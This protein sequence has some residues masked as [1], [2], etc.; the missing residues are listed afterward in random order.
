MA[1]AQSADLSINHTFNPQNAPSGT[2][3]TSTF[4]VHNTGPDAATN[5]V[6][7]N[8]LPVQVPLVS[9]VAS[10]FSYPAEC[11]LTNTTLTCNLGNINPNDNKTIIIVYTLGGSIGVWNNNGV[12]SSDTFDPL[13]VNNS[14]PKSVT[15]TNSSNLE[16]TATPLGGSLIAGDTFQYSLRV[17][18]LGP[19]PVPSEAAIVI[20]YTV[21]TNIRVTGASSGWSCSPGTGDAGTVMGCRSSGSLAV[22]GTKNLTLNAVAMGALSSAVDTSFTL[23]AVMPDSSILPDPNTSNNNAIITVEITAGSDVSVGKTVVI[24]NEE[25][26]YTL[27]PRFNGGDSLSNEPITITD[28]YNPAEFTFVEWISD[29]SLDGW[30]CT[31]PSPTGVAMEFSCTR[32]GYSGDNFTNMPS[33]KFKAAI[34]VPSALFAT[35]IAEIRLSGRQD[36][37]SGNNSS[38]VMV[39]TSGLTDMTTFKSVSFTPVVVGQ[40]FQYTVFVRNLGPW[41]VL[42]GQTITVTDTLPDQVVITDDPSGSDWTCTVSNNGGTIGSND[43]PVT[44]ATANPVIISCDYIDG[45]ASGSSSSLITIPAQ[46]AAEGE[47]DNTACV[48]LAPKGGNPRWREELDTSN[49]CSIL[50]E[51][52]ISATIKK[53]DLKIAKT[54]NPDPVDAG[55]QLTYTLTVINTGPDEATD[56]T[57]TDALGS[58]APTGGLQQVT[59]ETVPSGGGACTV[60]GNATPNFP[61]NG[62]AHLLICD[63]PSLQKDEQAVV[64]VVVLPTIAV[65]GPRSNTATVYS[66]KIGDPHRDDN[67]ITMES[68][69]DEVYDLTVSAWATSAGVS[70]ATQA[71]ANSVILFTT[72]VSSIGPST[73]PTAKV[74]I[75]LPSNAAFI[76]LNS[77]GGAT[78]TSV[79]DPLSGTTGGVLT[80]E[81]AGGIPSN[82]YRDISYQVMAPNTVGS[83]IVSVAEVGLIDPGAHDPESNLTNNNASAQ[84]TI[85]PAKADIQASIADAPDPIFLGELTTYTIY[86]YNNGPSLATDVTLTSAFDSPTGLFSYQGALTV[87]QGGDC[88]EPAI[89]TVDGYLTCTWSSLRA[90]ER[91]IITYTMHA[92]AIV[93]PN[94][95][96]IN[97]TSVFASATEEDDYPGNDTDEENTTAIRQGLGINGA[98]LGITKTAS[99]N[100]VA[101]DEQFSYTLMVHNYGPNDV[102]PAQGAQIV[103]ILPDGVL[104]ASI[105]DDCSYV[106]AS[107]T[108]TCLIGALANG[109]DHVVTVFVKVG[110]INQSRVLV[111]TVTVDMPDDLD[112]NNNDAAVTV[113]L[114]ATAIPAMS[115]WGLIFLSLL[116]VLSGIWQFKTSQRLNKND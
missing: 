99:K 74:I 16:L 30:T 36:P 109:D 77:V 79:P 66:S 1:F 49:D 62:I 61:M 21:P 46:I 34:P 64:K 69:V 68:Q 97:T 91:A 40:D 32:A 45:L 44:S 33:I 86:V 7:T 60:D 25:L 113:Y 14:A 63:F 28:T 70:P 55:E 48:S 19:S 111:N 90:G 41:D 98:D 8:N 102:T 88:I 107:R 53:A 26:V 103:D 110:N 116:L 10:F 100:N 76:Q 31:T 39:N 18:N 83:N 42:S 37:L 51:S 56:I 87:D 81:W 80:C 89:G 5:V 15:T 22:N 105:P 85:T 114:S 82:A 101:R 84:V 59:I 108:L 112:L 72:R 96:G 67:E 11:S 92:D 54:A 104:L 65:S 29:P 47:I 27:T 73:A 94:L 43:Y 106:D 17:E 6:L 71:P 115:M 9:G 12:V 52:N 95:T 20:Q 93:L 57:L 4:V 13:L 2:Q 35:N 38:S 24:S 58:L 23:S 3:F 50:T 75:T 78:C